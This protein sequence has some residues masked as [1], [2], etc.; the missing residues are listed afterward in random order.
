MSLSFDL[1]KYDMIDEARQFIESL[2]RGKR[3][4][5]EE[6]ARHAYLSI[7]EENKDAHEICKRLDKLIAE[8]K[9]EFEDELV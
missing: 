3:E 7:L 4:L 9:S 8:K 6:I 5:S 1:V 2:C